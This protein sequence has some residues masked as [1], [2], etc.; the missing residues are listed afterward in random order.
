MPKQKTL[1][2]RKHRGNQKPEAAASTADDQREILAGL[3]RVRRLSLQYLFSQLDALIAHVKKV[4]AQDRHSEA[5]IEFT[6]RALA[7]A[8]LLRQSCEESDVTAALTAALMLT[9]SVHSVVLLAQE[10][11]AARGRKVLEA[12]A[13]GGRTRAAEHAVCSAEYQA[14]VESLR[15]QNPRMSKRSLYAAV[16]RKLG[17]SPSIIRYHAEKR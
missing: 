3:D 16:A 17:V 8:Q 13:A 4:S 1:Q 10:T 7:A 12:A 15:R 6:D 11:P 14:Q 5:I 2:Q 9:T